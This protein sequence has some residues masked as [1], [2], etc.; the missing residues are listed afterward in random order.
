[1]SKR[2]E[3]LKRIAA[4]DFAIVELNL[5]LDSHQGDQT[6]ASKLDEYITK[7]NELQNEFEREFGPLVIASK[8]GNRWAWISNP[9]PWDT[10]KEGDM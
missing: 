10:I 1:M 7:S 3:L 2:E 5:F 9:W 4:Y 8:E 6:V